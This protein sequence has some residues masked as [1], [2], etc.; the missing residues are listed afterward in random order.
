MPKEGPTDDNGKPV[1]PA[2]KPWYQWWISAFLTTAMMA[3]FAL[4]HMAQ[5][6]QTFYVP[7]AA[8]AFLYFNIWYFGFLP[9][10]VIAIH[11]NQL[12]VRRF[13]LPPFTP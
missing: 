10:E 3:Q 7:L 9:T 6:R 4:A 2:P 5:E 1:A 12:S 11:L 8:Q 13:L